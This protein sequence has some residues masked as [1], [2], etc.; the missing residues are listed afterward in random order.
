MWTDVDELCG[1]LAVFD[2]TSGNE[3]LAFESFKHYL[4]FKGRGIPRRILRAF[5]EMV[6]WEGEAAHLAFPNEQWRRIN[7]Y[8][9]LNQLLE[10]NA[11]L[12]FGGSSEEI[13]GT[14]FDR[15]KLG[16]LYVVDWIL[17]QGRLEFTASAVLSASRELS[18]KIALAEQIARSSTLALLD[19]LVQGEYLQTIAPKLDQV[20]IEKVDTEE[21]RYRLTDRRL[22]E[23]SGIGG[24][25]NAEDESVFAEAEGGR[26]TPGQRFGGYELHEKLG[27]GG[28]GVVYHAW[29]T[30]A[31]RYVAL[32]LLH[33]W[34]TNAPNVQERFRRELATLRKLKHPNIVPFLESGEVDSQLFLAMEFI[35]GLDLGQVIKR[36]GALDVETAIEVLLPIAQGIEFAH[37]QGF[38]RLDVKSGNIRLAATG[39]VYLMDLGIAKHQ[40]DVMITDQSGFVGTPSYLAPEQLSGKVVDQRADIY[41]FGIVLYETL[42]GNLPF[43]GRDSFDVGM[44]HLKEEPAPPSK[45]AAIPAEL[46]AAILRCLKKDPDERFQ[47]MGQVI[48]LLKRFEGSP[49]QSNVVSLVRRAKQ[50]LDQADQDKNSRTVIETFTVIR[51]QSVASAAPDKTALPLNEVPWLEVSQDP[52]SPPQHCP[53]T[54]EITTIGRDADNDIC[55]FSA[56]SV[57]RYQARILLEEGR[58]SLVDLNSSNGTYLNGERVLSAMPL[59]DGDRVEIGAAHLLF[60][61]SH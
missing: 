42:T 19:I 8:A 16:I 50:E 18:S 49:W 40:D 41:S 38:A 34:L 3:Q 58:F 31:R 10:K 7:F 37:Q 48:E 51:Q 47:D 14:R 60:H 25:A 61:G 53:L 1:E 45:F 26:R 11:D 15:Q 32:K 56:G 17:R 27:E 30:N 35:D 12:L 52:N 4:R 23:M 24:A 9:Q 55:L 5:N 2:E 6:A 21:T 28:M 13:A 46:E 39:K 59:K 36:C 43:V 29:D 22:A 44:K 57:S 54:K 33:P 20:A